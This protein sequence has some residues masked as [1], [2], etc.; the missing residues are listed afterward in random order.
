MAALPATH[1]VQRRLQPV[2]TGAEDYGYWHAF[3][4]AGDSPPGRWLDDYLFLCIK[5]GERPRISKPLVEA[6]AANR[7]LR[8]GAA[9]PVALL[10]LLCNGVMPMLPTPL[11]PQ[12][13]RSRLRPST[14]E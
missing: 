10:R 4:S 14:P 11:V 7:E 1:D 3:R 2:E 8:R 12:G 6:C 5:A 13:V 9:I